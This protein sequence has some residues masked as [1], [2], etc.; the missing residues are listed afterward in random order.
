MS[1][2]EELSEPLRNRLLRR[3]DW[4]LLLSTPRPSKSIVFA[5]GVLREAV[6]VVSRECFPAPGPAPAADATHDLAVVVDPAPGVLADAFAAVRPGGSLYGEWYSP[7]AGGPQRIRRQLESQG[8]EDVRCY[9]PWP[10][11]NRA[12]PLFW[13]PLEAPMALDYFLATRPR[14]R[15]PRLRITNAVLRVLW[16]LAVRARILVPVCATAGKPAA[17]DRQRTSADTAEGILTAIAVRWRSF[18]L[19]KAPGRLSA[20]LLTG[21]THSSNKVVALVFADSSPRPQLVVKFARSPDADAALQREAAILGIVQERAA[22]VMGVPR[23]LFT[24][25]RES[26]SAVAESVLDGQ[27]L[28]TQLRR[29]NYRLF[30]L[31]VTDWLSHLALRR[32][33]D[34]RDSWWPE[35]VEL[36][37]AEFERTYAA[38]LDPRLLEVT[39]ERLCAVTDVPLVVEQRDC[40]PWNV[41]VDRSGRVGIVDWESAEARGLPARDLVYFLTYAAFFI[42]GAMASGAF[43]E[44][45]RTMLDPRTFTGRVVQE[46]LGRYLARLGL[47]SAILSPLRLLTWI[48][49]SRSEYRRIAADGA[50]PPNP[51]ALRRSLFLALWEEELRTNP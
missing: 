16:R 24:I 18:D 20:L 14:K 27:P 22:D 30:A 33:P 51:D 45:Y 39:H 1:G 32:P 43:R 28:S 26:G 47:D 37:L 40:A 4:R 49:H 38:V 6:R 17:A 7:L 21:G 2:P 8:F 23:V 9:W 13:L 42:D 25:P 12:P 41:L 34:S 31:T 44:S 36:P 50:A 10:W 46:C 29:D 15:S 5:N 19:G 48:L 35:L 3:A 11:P